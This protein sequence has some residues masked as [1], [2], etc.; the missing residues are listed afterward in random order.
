MF[1]HSFNLQVRGARGKARALWR[2]TLVG[3]CLLLHSVA[4]LLLVNCTDPHPI[5]V[6]IC[7]ASDLSG[8]TLRDLSV[9]TRRSEAAGDFGGAGLPGATAARRRVRAKA[10]WHRSGGQCCSRGPGL[11]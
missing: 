9:L 2:V 3:A 6:R 4:C 8:V 11:L 1:I 10:A 5:V 7:A